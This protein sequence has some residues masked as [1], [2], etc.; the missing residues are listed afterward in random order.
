MTEEEWSSACEPVRMLEFVRRNSSKRK[1]RLLV[2]GWAR[3][4]CQIFVEGT[5]YEHWRRV[6]PIVDEECHKIITIVETDDQGIHSKACKQMNSEMEHAP[7][8]LMWDINATIETD[9][10]HWLNRLPILPLNK[11]QQALLDVN[12]L[13]ELAF[14]QD[15]QHRLLRDIFGNPFRPVTILPEWRTSTVLTLATGIYDERAFDRMPILADALGDAG[16]D[17]EEILQHCRRPGPHTRGCFAVDLILG[18]E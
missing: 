8:G 16:C 14:E 1:L 10:G 9:F 3:R 4:Y 12:R 13:R 18:K 7:L 5:Q 11:R 17:N 2:C 6:K 15:F